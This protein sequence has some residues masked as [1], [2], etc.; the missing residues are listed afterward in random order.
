MEKTLNYYIYEDYQ[1]IIEL[2]KGQV[3]LIDYFKLKE[4][5]I[6]DHR[7]NPSFNFILDIREADFA[8]YHGVKDEISKYINFAQSMPN[9]VAERKTALLTKTPEQVV[10]MTFYKLSSSL[11]ITLQIFSTFQS[12]LTWLGIK[13][14]KSDNEELKFD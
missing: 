10:A 9:V 2:V 5:E 3:E 13:D 11:P 7:Y 12:A 1:L 14:F 4:A 6:Q 8:I